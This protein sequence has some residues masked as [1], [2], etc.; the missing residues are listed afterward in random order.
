MIRD[1]RIPGPKRIDARKVG[2]SAPSILPSTHC[3]T[4]GKLPETRGTKRS[5]G[6]I[7]L[8]NGVKLIQGRLQP[9][10]ELPILDQDGPGSGSK[11]NRAGVG[12]FSTKSIPGPAACPPRRHRSSDRPR[13]DGDVGSRCSRRLT[14]PGLND[15]AGYCRT[16]AR[17]INGLQSRSIL[18]ARQ[19]CL[20]ITHQ[21]RGGLAPALGLGR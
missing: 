18:H 5:D 14:A 9:K 1:G 6:D 21:C 17:A 2:T 16:M 13:A 7:A 20:G 15:R 19:R 10:V 8:R 12:E 3:L 11:G 4:T